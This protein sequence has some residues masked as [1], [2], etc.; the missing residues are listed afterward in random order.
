MGFIR[1]KKEFFTS[2]VARRIFFLF[3]V[4]AM[5]PLTILAGITFFFASNQLTHQATRRLQQAFQ[6]LKKGN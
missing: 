5:L 4:C 3:I 2:R 6:E 1:I